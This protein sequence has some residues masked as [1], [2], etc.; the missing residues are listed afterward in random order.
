[1]RASETDFRLQCREPLRS[2]QVRSNASNPANGTETKAFLAVRVQD[3]LGF[4][5]ICWCRESGRGDT[6]QPERDK[7][8]RYAEKADDEKLNDERGGKPLPVSSQKDGAE[9]GKACRADK[10]ILLYSIPRNLRFKSAGNY[11]L[12][13]ALDIPGIS[14]ERNVPTDVIL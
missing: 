10:G 6:D 1:M 13:G 9:S 7:L 5:N 4:F 11:A 8:R 12:A 2:K 14:E 3:S